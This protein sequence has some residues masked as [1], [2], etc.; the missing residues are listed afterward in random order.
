MRL[1]TL[2]ILACPDCGG[3]LTLESGSRTEAGRVES[4]RLR[5]GCCKTSFEIR[6][7]IPR[8][9]PKDDY[10]GSFGFQWNRFRKT[11]LDSRSGQPISRRRFYASTGWSRE[12]LRGRLLLDAG[13]GAGRFAEVALEDGAIVV[14]MDYSSAVEAC[15]DNLSRFSEIDVVQ[16]DIFRL[17]FQRSRFDGVYS[18][19][20]LQ[21][22]PD[23]QR[24]FHSLSAPL[25]PGGQLAVDVYP[26]LLRNLLWS[27]YWLRPVTKRM[28]NR[29]L[30]ALI[31]RSIR[32]LLMASNALTGIPKV[33]PKLKYLIPV[34]NYRG[35]YPLDEDQLL[36]WSVLDTFDMLAPAHDH[37]QSEAALRRWFRDAR[38]EQIQVFRDGHVIGRA[39]KPAAEHSAASMCNS[40]R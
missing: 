20:V 26:K 7:F 29:K 5:C 23:P 25:R 4:G 34:A 19:G 9:V 22:T 13:C 21:H 31:E 27:K 1:E 15:R 37:P 8:F 40:F 11:Q 3:D 12:E 28:D 30:F 10:A 39:T 14:A 17:P 16:A 38:L 2:S 24:A 35:V 6:G 18:L 33:G 36:E 32:R